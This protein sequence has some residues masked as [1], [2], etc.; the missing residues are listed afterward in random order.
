[1]LLKTDIKNSTLQN[2]G[3]FFCRNL[4]GITS[5]QSRREENHGGRLCTAEEKQIR[6]ELGN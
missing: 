4:G 3:N 2:Q 5:P 1:M 6:K